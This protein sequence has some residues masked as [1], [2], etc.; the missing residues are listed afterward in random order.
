M[1]TVDGARPADRVPGAYQTFYRE[2]AAAVRGEG[3]VPVPA[4][5]AREVLR[6][7][8]C[9]RRSSAEGRTLPFG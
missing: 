6:V 3:P 7:L 5:E 2:M 9:A 4:T 8:E 1:T